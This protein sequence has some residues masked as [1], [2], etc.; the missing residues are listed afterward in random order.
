MKKTQI[1]KLS[2]MSLMTSLC[3][4]QCTPEKKQQSDEWD[5]LFDGK[6]LNGWTKITGTADFI[7]EDS[8][9]V[10]ITRSKTPN[11]FL[12]SEKQYDDFILEV[13]VKVE[14]DFGNSGVQIRSHYDPDGKNGKGLVYGYQVEI[15]PTERNWS[16]GIFDEGRRKWL[17]PLSLN[18]ES[19]KAFKKGQ[20]NTFHI[21]AIGHEIKTW[22]NGVETSYIADDADARGFIGFQVHKIANP[23]HEGIRTYFK[24]IRIKTKNL[25][26]TPFKKDVFVVNNL[27]N[28]LTTYEKDHGWQLLFNGKNGQGWVGA[29]KDQFPASGWT[30]NNEILSIEASGGE[31]SANVGD[32]VTKNEYSTFDLAF[33]FQLTEG[34]NSGVK[35]FVTLSENNP[36]SAIGPEYQILD[37]KRHPDAKKGRNGNR[38]LASLYDLIAAKKQSRFVKPVGEWNKGRVIVYPDN[39]VE[40]YL[41][42]AKVLEYHRGS[43]AFR[44]L[45]TQSKHKIWKNF[46]EATE[47]HILLQD[48]GNKVSFKNIKIKELK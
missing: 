47:G 31:E 33:D 22:I 23:K 9:I 44:N 3:L 16:G 42:G 4:A 13:D 5:Y 37:D 1:I 24:N 6:T 14:D 11:T 21:E 18:P 41:N 7:V 35:Y 27:K 40:H 45:V 17:Y 10:G 38:T 15:D 48:H 32:I 30:V 46:G 36:G 20:Y 8:A 26:S 25:K 29:Y 2:V 28:E 39:K 12:V 19:Q 43:E 34:A